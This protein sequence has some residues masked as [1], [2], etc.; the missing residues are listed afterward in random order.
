MLAQRQQ[1]RFIWTLKWKATGPQCW[2]GPGLGR[3]TCCPEDFRSGLR[4]VD[5]MTC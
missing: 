3:G 1:R 5:M 4:A 2:M